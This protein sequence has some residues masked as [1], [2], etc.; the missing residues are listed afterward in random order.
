[1]H[2]VDYN[3]SN[4]LAT[5]YRYI[6]AHAQRGLLYLLCLSVCLLVRVSATTPT[7]HIAFYAL[8]E[9]RTGLLYWILIMKNLS[10][11]ELWC[12]LLTAITAALLE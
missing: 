2:V 11:Q 4:Y 8:N 5:G 12:H 3:L 6:G 7:A 10:I 9:V 1:M